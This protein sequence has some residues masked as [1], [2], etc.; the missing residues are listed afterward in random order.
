MLV[1]GGREPLAGALHARRGRL[2]GGGAN[3]NRQG[4]EA[5][6]E[7]GA[8]R[9]LGRVER[10]AGLGD[11]AVD[12]GREPLLRDRQPVLGGLAG[13]LQATS[14]ARAT[15]SS[16]QR[17]VVSSSRSLSSSAAASCVAVSS[18]ERTASSSRASAV[19]RSSS[20][21]ARS[22]VRISS[23]WRAFSDRNRACDSRLPSSARSRSSCSATPRRSAVS[24][25]TRCSTRA[26]ASARATASSA[27]SFVASS[28]RLAER[29]SRTPVS[30][31]RML[32]PEVS[33]TCSEL[34]GSPRS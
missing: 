23:R 3:L 10:L 6:G 15:A 13:H 27:S 9:L 25:S 30:L 4:V 5:L 20:T 26:S 28:L 11:A 1:Q 14:R 17:L 21:L 19:P 32:S 29:D 12:L 16:G 8:K 31:S 34:G 2:V 33:E 7:F 18:R 24:S 22:S